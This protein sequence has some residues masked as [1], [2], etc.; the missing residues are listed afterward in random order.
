MMPGI[1]MTGTGRWVGILNCSKQIHSPGGF[2]K[3]CQHLLRNIEA[4]H[5]HSEQLE[6]QT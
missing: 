1:T 6:W 2:L 5:L 3:D 4:W